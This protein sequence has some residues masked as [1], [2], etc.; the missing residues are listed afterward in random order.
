MRYYTLCVFLLI[1][2]ICFSQFGDQLIISTEAAFARSVFAADVDGD[3]DLDVLSAS[4][5]DNKVA[6]Y[7]NQDGLG[8]FG[9]QNVITNTLN[10]AVDVFAVDLDGDE[11]IDVL[12][13]SKGFSSGEGKVVWF[14]NM[15]GQGTFS[16]ET[17]LSNQTQ[18]AVSVYAADLDGDTDMDVLSASF[19]DNTVSWFENT[20]GMGTFGDR[21]VITNQA[22]STRDVIA[23]DIDGDNDLD[24]LTVSTASDEI[25]W[26]KNLNGQGNFGSA[27]VVN[28]T[29]NGP[30]SVY[31]ADLDGD[32]DLDVISISPADDSVYWFENLDGLGNFGDENLISQTLEAPQSIFAVDLDNDLD[33][34]V[35]SGSGIDD[36]VVWYKNLDGSGNFSSEII[37]SNETDWAN[38]I[39]AADIN[40]DNFVDVLSASRVDN[41]IAWYKNSGVFGLADFLA[42]TITIIPNPVT[43]TLSIETK[44]VAVNKVVI[45]DMLGRETLSFNKDFKEL[46]VS[47]LQDGIWFIEITTDQGKINKK[48]IKK[49]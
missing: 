27:L 32:N 33:L 2:G 8:A 18:G 28:N 40:N 42:N 29:I 35:I 24:V 26:F 38:S 46:E 3:G 48:F 41:K 43:D 5:H 16:K 13:T 47:T 19:E 25:L 22:L 45:S 23:V 7:E 21:Q 49:N 14:K 37:I 6:W 15:D 17:L 11:D 34:D 44:G 36:N 31:A 30:L 1:T 39:I 4:E 12:A 20:N 9:S 10:A